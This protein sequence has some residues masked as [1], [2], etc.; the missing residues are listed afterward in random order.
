[1][2]LQEM[3]GFLK[4]QL[5]N[6]NFYCSFSKSV[7]INCIDT[8]AYIVICTFCLVSQLLLLYLDDFCQ[9]D[10]SSGRCIFCP[11]CQLIAQRFLCHCS[12]IFL[13]SSAEKTYHLKPHF[14][15]EAVWSIG[16]ENNSV[17]SAYF[18]RPGIMHCYISPCYLDMCLIQP[19]SFC[20]KSFT[21]VLKTFVL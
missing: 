9:V 15:H 11:C 7:Q 16:I 8:S 14:V 10:L 5:I 17:N 20:L 18:P 3:Q 2:I 12:E 19:R 4:I 6:S 1:M 21:A 13:L